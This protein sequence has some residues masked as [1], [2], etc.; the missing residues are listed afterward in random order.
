MSQSLLRTPR[1]SP[2]KASGFP[3]LIAALNELDICAADIGN[4]YINAQ[5]REKVHV[6]VGPELF[7][8]EN[9]GKTAIIVRALYG[10]KSAGASWRDHLSQVIQDELHFKPTRADQ[11]VHIRP[12][13]NNGEKYYAYLIVYV[14]NILSIDVNPKDL[15]DELGATFRIKKESIGFPIMYL[16]TNVK[17][18]TVS[19]ELGEDV[20]CY[21][22]G[23]YAYVKEAIRGVKERMKE[24]DLVFPKS[25]SRTPFTNSNYRPEIDTSELCDERLIPV[26]QNMIG[27]FRWLC[28][29]GR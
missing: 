28:E 5:C 15:I 12:K 1:L 3:F 18:W 2:E 19:N 7:G 16:G 11:D 6:T 8:E 17:K 29:L 26:Y 10:L 9:A 22:T 14:D 25:K 23:S 27:I 21:A 4:A 20:N 13:I 24:H